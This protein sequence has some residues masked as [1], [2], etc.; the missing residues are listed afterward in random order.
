M[1]KIE[2]KWKCKDKNYHITKEGGGAEIYLNV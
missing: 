2:G 1:I